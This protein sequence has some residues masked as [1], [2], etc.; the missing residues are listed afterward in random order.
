M[1]PNPI[2]EERHR[3]RDEYAASFNNDLK[4]IVA[5][6]RCQQA[7]HEGETVVIPPRRPTNWHDHSATDG[8]SQVHVELP[9]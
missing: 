8:A 4:T 6:I 9:S 3:I 7:E 5:D 2:L 1:T